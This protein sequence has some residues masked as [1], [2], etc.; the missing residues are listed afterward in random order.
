MKYKDLPSSLDDLDVSVVICDDAGLVIYKNPVAMKQIRLPKR[1]THISPR[2]QSPIEP[3]DFASIIRP[4][5]PAILTVDTG[6]RLARAL[7]CSYGDLPASS[8]LWIFPGFL[9][10]T[11]YTESF[12]EA[13]RNLLAYAYEICDIVRCIDQKSRHHSQS[14]HNTIN[15][16]IDER[17]D[18]IINGIFGVSKVKNNVD[19]FMPAESSIDILCSAANNTLARI[20]FNVSC[21][22]ELCFTPSDNARLIH[23]GTL[24]SFFAHFLHF[25]MLC[26]GSG[27]VSVTVKDSLNSIKLC[28]SFT[29]MYPPFYTVNC[30]SYEKLASLS[31]KTVIDIAIIRAIA[32]QSGYSL[33]FGVTGDGI[34]NTTLEFD[35]PIVLSPYCSEEQHE[36]T[37]VLRQRDTDMYL[38]N[39]FCKFK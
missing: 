33:S 24:T 32:A 20:G 38:F 27:G 4:R 10:I 26:S 15:R 8:Y 22:S 7:V 16:R 3:L 37:D 2:L 18:A 1:G 39:M 31:P 6:D 9:Q 17:M 13:E 23:F 35:L 36:F 30:D 14:R 11:P 34:D 29:C 5:K 12:T 28:A 21:A 19:G 25:C